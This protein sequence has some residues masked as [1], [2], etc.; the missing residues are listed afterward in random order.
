MKTTIAKPPEAK[1]DLEAT[2]GGVDSR[3]LE[4][5]RILAALCVAYKKPLD[6]SKDLGLHEGGGQT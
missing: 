2:T 3:T 6:S 5:L 1:P 4:A